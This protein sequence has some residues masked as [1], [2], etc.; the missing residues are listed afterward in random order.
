[1]FC[2]G[3]NAGFDFTLGCLCEYQTQPLIHLRGFCPYSR[4]E[5]MRFTIVQSVMNP[6]E[7]IMVGRQSAQIRYNLELNQWIFSDHR[8]NVTARSWASQKSFALGKQNWR[9]SGDQYP[10]PKEV[11]D[12]QMKLTGC[13][14]DEFTCDDGQCI[15]MVERCDQRPQ[16]QDESDELSC[17]ILVLQ[18][19]YNTEVHPIAAKGIQTNLL[20]IGV[21]LTLQ[22]V[23]A[24][25]EVD[26]S[27]SFKYKISLTWR[28]NRARY[29]N[30]K[31]DS[32]NNL[33][34]QEEVKML[35]L[36]LVI[37]WNTDQEETTRLG[38][39]W[40]WKTRVLVRREGNFTRNPT[41]DIDEA[42]VFKGAENTLE[43]EQTYTHAFQCVFK[44]AKYPFDTQ[45]YVQVTI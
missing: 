11:Y 26:Y 34:R 30:L 4:I 38:E 12:I 8:L 39:P 24:I 16:C 32:S 3:R 9:I 25:E 18:H 36:P 5:H 45:V 37:Y 33:I 13:K 35:W 7:I 19:G 27:I 20:P 23:I 31:T 42:E 40:E 1:M 22:K 17:K 6:N 2:N 15:D 44:L 29:Q 21:A 28:E 41:Q 43:M 10:C 14:Q